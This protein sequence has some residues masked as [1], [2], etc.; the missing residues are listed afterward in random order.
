M[1]IQTKEESTVDIILDYHIRMVSYGS[2][3]GAW[4]WK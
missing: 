2:H 1:K 3:S 4:E